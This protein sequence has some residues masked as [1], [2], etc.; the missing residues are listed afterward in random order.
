MKLF[1]NT[2]SAIQRSMDL[3]FKRHVL[4][5]GN[6]ANAETPNY[7]ARELD[8]AGELQ[9]AMGTKDHV[10]TTT[11]SMHMDLSGAD[12][13]HITL[14]NSGAIKSDGNNVDLDVEMGKISSNAR[15]YQNSTTLLSLKLSLLRAATQVRGG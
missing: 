7:K 6:V 3:E 15:G 4:L 12:Q 13:A 9:D 1:D 8:F 5:T 10:M 2:F 11:N 14:D